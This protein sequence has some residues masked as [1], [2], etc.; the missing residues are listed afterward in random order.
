[1]TT[2]RTK[3]AL[4]TGMKDATR[5]SMIALSDC[6]SKKFGAG[7]GDL[8]VGKMQIIAL[9]ALGPLTVPLPR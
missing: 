5:G 4:V 2:A 7:E 8:G 6:G 3:K 9:E 1:M